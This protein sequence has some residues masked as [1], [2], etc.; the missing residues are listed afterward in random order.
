MS[1]WGKRDYANNS[2]KFQITDKT[3]NTGPELYG[4]RVVAVDP[5]EV[6]LSG[7]THPGWAVKTVGTGGRAGRVQTEILV[8]M[9]DIKPEIK[10]PTVLNPC[11]VL[12]NF[13]VASNITQSIKVYPATAPS[14]RTTGLSLSKPT[15]GTF[16]GSRTAVLPANFKLNEVALVGMWVYWSADAGSVSIR[17]S[18]DAFATKRREFSWAYSGQLHKGWNLLTVNPNGDGTTEPN[19]ATWVVTGAQAIDE[20]ING[21]QIS[22]STANGV[23]TEIFVDSIFAHTTTPTRGCVSMGFDRFGEASIPNMALPILAQAKITGYWAGDANLIDGNTNAYQYCRQVY[24]FGWDVISQGKNHPDYVSVGATQLG[25]DFDYGVGV[26]TRQ[27]FLRALNLFSYPLSS[28]D[29]ST[30]AMLASKGVVMARSGWSW[31]VHPNEYNAGPKL[32][33]HGAV[34]IGGKTLAQAKKYVDTAVTYG[35]YISIFCHGLTA[36]GNGGTPPADTLLWYQ[37]DYQ[38]L[39]DYIVAYRDQGV[40]D[41]D[42]PTQ[43]L[44]KRA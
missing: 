36:G 22:I 9:R 41:T 33:G 37:N 15:T 7:A 17:F 16:G 13:T 38:S 2:P 42:S 12:A 25:A 14:G 18:S 40:L 43:Y 39:V 28:N 21:I 44:R 5:T 20:V 31:W 26:F 34:N 3:A 30:D 32:I 8:A 19:G 29:V 23:A 27:G 6:K 24:A 4:T 10:L 1:L 35:V 11:T